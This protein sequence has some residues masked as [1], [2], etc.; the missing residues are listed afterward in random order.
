MIAPARLRRVL[1]G[2]AV[3]SLAE[4]WWRAARTEIGPLSWLVGAAADDLAYGAGVWVGCGRERTVTP[5][6]PRFTSS[7][8]RSSP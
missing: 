8:S 7:P 1:I 5:L 3:A 6:L 4:E 2:A